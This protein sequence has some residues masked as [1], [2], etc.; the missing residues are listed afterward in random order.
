MEEGDDILFFLIYH[1]LL[2]L[3]VRVRAP[4]VGDDKPIHVASPDSAILI[5]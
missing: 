4:S 2:L 1:L 3:N 5:T